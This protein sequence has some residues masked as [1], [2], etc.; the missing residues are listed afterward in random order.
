M[1]K[2]THCQ[3]VNYE[4]KRKIELVTPTCRVG[5]IILHGDARGAG[6]VPDDV[7]GDPVDAGHNLVLDAGGAGQ[8]HA[9]DVEPGP[10]EIN[11]AVVGGQLEVTVQQD[12]T[13]VGQPDLFH[14]PGPA[15]E[16]GVVGG[17]ERPEQGAGSGQK[18]A[19][20]FRG[21]FRGFVFRVVFVSGVFRGVLDGV[22]INF[23]GQVPNNGCVILEAVGVRSDH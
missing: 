12:L 13:A 18:V 6:V 4:K 1:A 11:E 2:K 23:S 22:W 8:L 3:Q 15:P 14:C 5:I 16:L 17:R 7:H 10:V 19:L 9:V 20:N 21:F